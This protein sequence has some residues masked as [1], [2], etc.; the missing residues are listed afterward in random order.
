[1][2]ETFDRILIIK[3]RYIGDVL[4]AT[5]LLRNLRLHY[6][7]AHLAMV[8][9]G[10]TEA[11][12]RHN[13]CVDEI[14]AL[15]RE[16]LKSWNPTARLMAPLRYLRWVRARRFHCVVDLTDADRSALLAT[17]SGAPVRVG[18]NAENRWRGRLYTHLARAGS[19]R[20]H[21]ADYQLET[22]RVLGLEVRSREPEL[23]LAPA[24]DAA[25][26]GWLARQGGVEDGAPFLA[27]HPGARWWFK[28]WPAERCAAL[29]DRLQTEDGTPVVFLG[30]TREAEFLAAVRASMRT[31]FRGGPGGLELL[32][33]AAVLR[34]ARAFLGNDNGPMHI[35]AAVRT[36]VVAR[37][38]PSDPAE[39][40]PWGEG[41]VV[42]YKGLDCRECWRR[43]TC[44]RGEANCLRQI[45][46]DEAMVAVRRVWTR[47]KERGN[48]GP[49]SGGDLPFSNSGGSSAPDALPSFM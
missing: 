2:P 3:L 43:G 24:E 18:F 48:R 11:I 9:N 5:P 26:G 40:G 8:V 41:H 13:R 36:P 45:T 22:L 21:N 34:R 46:V 28:Q 29:A 30:G 38:G 39:W 49:S 27:F 15:D 47:K 33:M 4:L 25:A 17:G 31:W 44:W 19:P 42:L 12:L 1:M 20:Q 7:R 6:P 35:A 37:F 14:L 16:E 32:E 23:P 10:G